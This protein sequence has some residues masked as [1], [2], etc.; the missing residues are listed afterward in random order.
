MSFSRTHEGMPNARGD[1]TRPRFHMAS[2]HDEAASA[3]AGH[4]VH[5]DEE[6]VQYLMPGSF[7]QPVMRV[8]DEHRHRWP[9]EYAAFQAGNTISTTG[10]PIE[11][12]PLLTRA[13]VAEL[14]AMEI[15]TVEQCAT[16]NDEVMGRTRTMGIRKI[17]ELAAAYLDDAEAGKQVAELTRLNDL[18]ETRN[19]EVEGK[20]KLQAAAIERMQQQILQM[21][22]SLTPAQTYVPMDHDPQGR[23][24]QAVPLPAAQPSALD[25]LA[26]P[27]RPV[28]K[29]AEAVA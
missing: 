28:R 6:R 17:R 11:A 20:L 19:A 25:S 15:H 27:R 14:K 3:S 5:R 23:V 21:G 29:A 24:A 13:Q 10:M 9:R 26:M 2:V 12:W 8:T 7:N 18:L 22:Q 16:L 1:S 4:P